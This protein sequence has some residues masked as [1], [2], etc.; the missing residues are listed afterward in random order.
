MATVRMVLHN[1]RVIK[2]PDLTLMS[3]K[4]VVK[5]W[6]RPLMLARIPPNNE[7]IILCVA[8]LFLR[9]N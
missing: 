5:M 4:A 2:S 6:P 7:K 9:F 1:A 8:V 3:V